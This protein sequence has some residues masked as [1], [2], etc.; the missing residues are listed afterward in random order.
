MTLVSILTLAGLWLAGAMF[1]W[2]IVAGGARNDTPDQPTRH[3]QSDVLGGKGEV[4][5]HGKD[6]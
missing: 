4:G 6:L 1:F 3:L 2:A 5:V